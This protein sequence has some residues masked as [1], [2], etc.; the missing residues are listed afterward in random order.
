MG[1]EHLNQAQLNVGKK[2]KFEEQVPKKR[3]TV[4]I[5]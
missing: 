1:F 3:Y 2:L 4:I 5:L